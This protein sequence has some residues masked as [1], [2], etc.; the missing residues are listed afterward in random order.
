MKYDKQYFIRKF[1]SIPFHKWTKRWLLNKDG[2]CCAL[3]H[4]GPR[5]PWDIEYEPEAVALI[6]LFA[7]NGEDVTMINDFSTEH[8]KIAILNALRS[9]K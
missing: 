2:Q 6:N 9:F 3:G 1:E 8:P 7:D 5:G 4:C